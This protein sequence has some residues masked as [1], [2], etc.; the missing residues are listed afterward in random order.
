MTSLPSSE[1]LVP[2]AELPRFRQHPSGGR[3]DDTQSP[4]MNEMEELADSPDT[5]AA[6]TRTDHRR[7]AAFAGSTPALVP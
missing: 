2:D 5:G 1:Q 7:K 6:T 4:F 3:Q